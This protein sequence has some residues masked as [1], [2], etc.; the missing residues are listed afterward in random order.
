VLLARQ[1]L[2]DR[3]ETPMAEQQWDRADV[4]AGF[5]EVDGETRGARNEA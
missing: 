5:E 1:V 2:R 4:G 3:L